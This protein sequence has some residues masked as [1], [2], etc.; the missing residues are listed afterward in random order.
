LNNVER[1]AHLDW[2]EQ[3][4]MQNLLVVTNASFSVSCVLLTQMILEKT[5]KNQVT[6]R[7]HDKG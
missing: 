7:A 2:L 3:K 4:L 1:F 5:K 6:L